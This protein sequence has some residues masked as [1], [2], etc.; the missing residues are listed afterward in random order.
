LKYVLLFSISIFPVFSDS[1]LK[2]ASV[3]WVARVGCIAA[4][5]TPIVVKI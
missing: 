3:G 4:R 5:H 1:S 2:G